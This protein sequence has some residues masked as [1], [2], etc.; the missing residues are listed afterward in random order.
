MS[1][2]AHFFIGMGIGL[3]IGGITF[4]LGAYLYLDKWLDR[5]R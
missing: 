1:Y 4:A 3:I 5:P 2:A